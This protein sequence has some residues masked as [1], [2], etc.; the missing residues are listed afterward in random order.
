M[1]CYDKNRLDWYLV[2]VKHI[3]PLG[4]FSFVE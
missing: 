3:K 2:N 4:D 1:M